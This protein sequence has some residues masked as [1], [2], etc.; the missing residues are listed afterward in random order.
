[1][2][3]FKKLFSKTNQNESNQKKTNDGIPNVKEIITTDYFENRY[4]EQ[5]L[6]DDKN[7]VDGCLKMVESYYL[8]NKIEPKIK[9]PINHPINLD[10]IVEEGMGFHMYCKAFDQEDSSIIFI[11]ANAFSIY[12]IKRN[13]FKLY[14][15]NEPEF[16]L[17]SMTLKYDRNG[18]VFSLYPFEYSLKVLENESRFED[19]YNK[20]VHHLENTPD[21]KEMLLKSIK[22]NKE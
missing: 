10:Q 20:I 1:M 12:L 15:D 16:P 13:N 17:R 5:N 11:L 2:N 9:D 21:I 22:E 8:D 19:L 7:R 6:V 14:Q 3:F 18:N 4:T